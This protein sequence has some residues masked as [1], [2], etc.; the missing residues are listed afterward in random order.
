[1]RREP[2]LDRLRAV[3]ALAVLIAHGGYYLFPL[4]PHYD[5]YALASWLG[6]EVFF[7]LS[8]FLVMRALLAPGVPDLRGAFGF[9]ARRLWRIV[10]LYWLFLG[11]NLVLA[12]LDG[13]GWPEAP[14]AYV[15]LIQNIDTPH[16]AF[17][18][19]AWNL[20]ILLLASIVLP[21]IAVGARSL[22][23][24]LRF[25]GVMLTVLLVLGIA[26]RAAWVI[27]YQPVWDEGV[28]KL[29][30]TRIDA[31]FYGALAAVAVLRRGEV[32]RGAALMVAVLGLGIAT[33]LFLWLPRDVSLMARVCAFFA[34]GI[35][36][37][38]LVLACLDARPLASRLVSAVSRWSYALY[39]VN[40]P[41]IFL[42]AWFGLGQ[43]TD[44]LYAL[45]RFALWFAATV[46]MAAV[47]H[48]WIERPLLAWTPVGRRGKG[49]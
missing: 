13:R 34:A 6:T 15:V 26:L 41:M 27:E 33:A 2:G 32:P 42:L 19:E 43:T 49:H 45:V 46:A 8:G 3:A 11:L 39:L 16:P 24:P 9:T 40:M 38:A 25:I 21:G 18:G 14:G 36:S 44:A 30:V 20:P 17:F 22:R 31:C 37:A 47:V 4:F 12:S 7:A 23:D 10:P 1:M 5:A 35:G 28:R 29:V 48:R